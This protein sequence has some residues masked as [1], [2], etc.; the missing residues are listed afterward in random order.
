MLFYSVFSVLRAFLHLGNLDNKGF[1]DL[2]LL[3][4]K[5]PVNPC[6]HKVYQGFCTICWYVF[7]YIF[8][9]QIQNVLDK[10]IHPRG[11]VYFHLFAEMPIH[12]Q[13]KGR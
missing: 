2:S 5:A 7:P 11:A 8:P 10:V 4:E 13:S 6:K 12:I 9:L 1:S 3:S